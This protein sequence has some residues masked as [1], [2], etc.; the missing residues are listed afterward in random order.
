MVISAY[1]PHKSAGMEQ[2]CRRLSEALARRGHS[3]IVLTQAGNDRPSI[4]EEVDNL[5]VYRVVQ[6]IALGPLW[7]VTYMTQMRRW[8]SRL[9]SEW[10]VCLCH[11]LY[12]HSAVFQSLCRS[13]GK[14]YCNRL[15]NTGAFSDI[16]FLRQHKGG[17]LLLNKALD[18][19]GFFCLS[20]VSREELLREKV[21]AEKIH[22]CRNFVDLGKFSP[23]EERPA[24]KE[25]LYLGRFH[26]QKNLP[27]LLEAFAAL[28]ESHP[29]VRLRLVGKGPEDNYIRTLVRQSPACDAI[30]VDEW[31]DDP[32]TAYRSA[33]AVVTASNAEGL[34]NVLVESLACGAPVITSDVSGARE[35]LDPGG[36]LPV[37]IPA[38][39]AIQGTGGYVYTPG[40]KEA[41]IQAMSRLA[42]DGDHRDELGRQAREQAVNVFSEE[43]T[44]EEFLAGAQAIVDS[45]K[46]SR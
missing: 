2:G 46:P 6:P 35:A 26:E 20:R 24:E 43:R 33:W 23:A 27:L 22:P 28:R 30:R 8:G 13:L 16:E 3:V 40:D 4:K 45:R 44:V 21:A 42:T 7:G 36:K 31:T 25:F 1:P 37:K 18:A 41:L 9:A 12:L 5:K 34:S 19:D 29:E 15:A 14:I 11:K 38:G 10:D 39:T 17:A 32:V